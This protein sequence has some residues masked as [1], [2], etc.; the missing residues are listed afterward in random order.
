[1]KRLVVCC[2]GTWNKPDQVCPT[3]VVR[4][5]NALAAKDAEGHDQIAHYVKGVG[6]K[7]RERW[8]GG[9]LGVGLSSNVQDAYRFLVER[10]EP[11]DTLY[12]FGFSRGAFT[13]RSTA[14]LVRNAGILR[15]EHSG[16]I[17]D[18]YELYRSDDEEDE[19]GGRNAVKFR[20]DHSYPDARIH[21][22]G[23][24]D[25]VGALGMPVGPARPPFISRLWRFHDTTLSSWVD[26]A[27]HAVSIDERRRPFKPTLW[28]EKEDEAPPPEQ[29]VE[30]VWFAGVHSDVGGGYPDPSLAELPLCWMVAKAEACGLAFQPG[31]TD[32]S[33]DPV[34]RMN[35]SLTLA[36]RLLIPYNRR[37]RA[38]KGVAVKPYVSSS[39]STRYEQDSKYRPKG[40]REWLDAARDVMRL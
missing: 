15:P 40:L 6:T 16:R 33:Q 21:F 8:I 32:R 19:P 22:I 37:L 24:W 5:K 3:N 7:P 18:A 17:E 39:A 14:G 20:A 34:V 2:D 36:Y 23:V 29:T 13:A 12:F 31:W 28:V 10:Y 35:D 25:T 26:H 4:V 1:M 27:Y 11:G 30:Q 9:G 38:A